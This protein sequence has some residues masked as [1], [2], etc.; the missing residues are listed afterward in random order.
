MQALGLELYE[1]EALAQ[2]RACGFC[3]ISENTFST[4]QLQ[5]AMSVV[6]K[7][8]AGRA[9]AYRVLLSFK[10]SVTSTFGNYFNSSL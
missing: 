3:L 6:G 10:T 4:E 5:T 7:T 2:E 9:F 1:E 8:R